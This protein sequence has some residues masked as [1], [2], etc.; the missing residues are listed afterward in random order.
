MTK[1]D[2]PTP[3]EIH[4]VPIPGDAANEQIVAY[5]A[6]LESLGW[7]A[8][9]ARTEITILGDYVITLSDLKEIE[10]SPFPDS[11]KYLSD[12]GFTEIYVEHPM[13]KVGDERIID[14][15]S[16]QVW[17]ILHMP[18]TEILVSENLGGQITISADITRDGERE[19]SVAFGGGD[20]VGFDEDNLNDAIWEELESLHTAIVQAEPG[21]SVDNWLVAKGVKRWP[22]T[23]F[24]ILAQ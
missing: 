23:I 22:G 11:L 12:K 20:Y 21:D 17:G 14:E 18:D 9:A 24:D 3:G 15:D 10:D 5:R 4:A 13:K 7:V 1:E 2:Y 8:P 16:W 6:L 19:L